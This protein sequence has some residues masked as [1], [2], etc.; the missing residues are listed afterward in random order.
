[1]IEEPPHLRHRKRIA[2]I[3]GIAIRRRLSSLFPIHADGF[4]V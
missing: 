2:F 3:A 1:M 4:H